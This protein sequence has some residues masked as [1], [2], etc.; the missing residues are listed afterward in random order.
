MN[1]EKATSKTKDGQ[2]LTSPSS[3]VYCIINISCFNI[4][5]SVNIAI[6]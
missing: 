4:K 2:E 3:Y 6:S 5:F 1:S